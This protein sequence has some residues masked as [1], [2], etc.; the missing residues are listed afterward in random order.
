MK[1][2]N[3]AH[4]DPPINDKRE[5]TAED[6]AGWY[7]IS[8]VKKRKLVASCLWWNGHE[9]NIQ[10]NLRN[11]WDTAALGDVRGIVR[12]AEV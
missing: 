2:E 3:V 4:F 10:P 6:W 8:G 12:L 7:Q 1:V 9:W 11:G 5:M